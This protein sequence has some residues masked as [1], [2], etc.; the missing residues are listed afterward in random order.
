MWRQVCSRHLRHVPGVRTHWDQRDVV[1]TEA[2]VMSKLPG[3]T[4]LLLLVI[5]TNIFSDCSGIYFLSLL[6]IHCSNLSHVLYDPLTMSNICI[7]SLFVG[8][9]W[10]V[11]T[12]WKMAIMIVL[13]IILMKTLCIDL[14]LFLPLHHHADL[15]L[16]LWFDLISL[17]YTY[18]LY[19]MNA[20][21]DSHIP[22]VS[23]EF[24]ERFTHTY[25]ILWIQGEV[26]GERHQGS[27]QYFFK[28]RTNVL[29]PLSARNSLGLMTCASPEMAESQ[30]VMILLC[31][32]AV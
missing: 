1:N 25:C 14:E 12:H 7:V 24:S 31:G 4:V 10:L 9:N 28:N 32:A 5:L 30:D 13:M 11:S 22:T 26:R 3:L 2:I 27:R 16:G 6:Y 17:Y 18:L 29:H 23:H 15:L 19:L 21:R 20:G 8:G